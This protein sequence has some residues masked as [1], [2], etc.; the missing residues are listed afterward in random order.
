MSG[1][2]GNGWLRDRLRFLASF[3]AAV[4]VAVAAVIIFAWA[5]QAR[6]DDRIARN[7]RD[8]AVLKARLD[9][10]LDG[11]DGKIDAIH[12]DVRSLLT[13]QKPKPTRD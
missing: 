13:R 12:S 8:V 3:G 6:Q 5:S 10:R 7:A 4:A 9:D 1:T 2:E 11:I